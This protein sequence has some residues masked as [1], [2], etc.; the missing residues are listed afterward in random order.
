MITLTESIKS[1]SCGVLIKTPE[2]YLACHTT[3]RKWQFGNWDIPKGG[4]EDG[5]TPEQCARRETLE[6]T[7]IDLSGTELTDMGRHRYSDTKDLHLFYCE[8][9]SID[10]KKLVCT[11]YFGPHN[12]PEIDGYRVTDNTDYYFKKLRPIITKAIEKL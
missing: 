5:E 4:I 3:G 7:G 10:T 9:P 8:I 1:L 2:G 11:T 12:R 6:E